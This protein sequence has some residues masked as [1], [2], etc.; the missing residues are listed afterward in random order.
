MSL[1]TFLSS[2]GHDIAAEEQKIFNGTVN[3]LEKVILPA[4]IAVTNEV[5]TITDWDTND[6]LGNLAGKAGAAIENEV[7]AALP[8]IIPKLQMA[9]TILASSPGQD[10]AVVLASIVRIVGAAPAETK[11]AFWIEFSG[12]LANALQTKL[13]ASGAFQVVQWFYKN[14]PST[15]AAAASL[16]AAATTTA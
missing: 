8:I 3:E 15:A 13:T 11:T 2:V 6:F 16:P 7:K 1:G 14:N 12:Q 9:Q 4:V 10:P 5:K